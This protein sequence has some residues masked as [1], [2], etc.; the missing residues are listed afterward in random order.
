M[1]NLLII[2]AGGVS[3]VASVKCAMNSDVFTKITLASRTKSKCDAIASFIKERLGV[4]VETA[5]IDAD[6]VEAVVTLIQKTGA[7]ILLNL[8]L[9]Y[10]DLSLMD[11]CLKTGI[12]YIDT[13]NYEHPDLAKFEYKEQW[14][15]DESFKKAGILG[16]LGSGFDPGVTNVFCAYAKQN[17]FDEIHYIDILDC[18][19][20]DHGYPFATNF[21]PEINLREVSAKGRYFENGQWIET[22]PMAI[23]MEWDYPE[24]GVKDSYLLYHEELESLV[25]NIPSLK[26]IRFFM[27]F[28]QSYLTHMKC[29]ENVGMLGIKPVKHKGVEIVPIEFLKTLLP[30]PASLGERTKG[31][32]NIGCVIRGVKD[33]K[34]KQVY[35][36]NVCNHEECFKET[37]SQAVS[38]T[39]GVPAMIGAK[40]VA[41]GIWS[42][43][44]VKNM[45]EF[46][47]KPFMDELNSQ[48]L[49]WKILEMKPD[50]GD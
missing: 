24:V 32:T 5:E 21:N 44:G 3:R 49:P 16:L 25:K 30:D 20:G 47:A 6:N 43:V 9:P 33:S 26:R 22:E 48:G 14:A 37:L 27:T 11:A 46:D 17:L 42:G 28:G 10:Q 1:A 13:A 4:S 8:A 40:L 50:L 29:L 18:N 34:D 36:Y 19:A 35:I 15:K 12:H 7:E 39:T 2:G 41:R 38:Y 45:E 31:Y 23:K